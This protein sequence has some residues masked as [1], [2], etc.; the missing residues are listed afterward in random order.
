[1]LSI[2]SK[3]SLKLDKKGSA[4]KLQTD[5][6]EATLEATTSLLKLL[7]KLRKFLSSAC[8][9]LCF[10]FCKLLLIQQIPGLSSEITWVF[11]RIGE[12]VCLLEDLREFTIKSTGSE[13]KKPWR[14]NRIDALC[15]FLQV[16]L[17]V[18]TY[19]LLKVFPTITH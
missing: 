1:V 7:M 10:Y 14:I 4:D 11:E 2:L 6:V 18:L 16:N 19:R 17:S 12:E 13:T 3:F 8:Y 5:G 15:E 9:I